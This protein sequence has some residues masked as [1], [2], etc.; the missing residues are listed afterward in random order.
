MNKARFVVTV[1][2]LMAAVLIVHGRSD[3]DR[4]PFRAPLSQLPEQVDSRISMDIPIDAGILKLLGDGYFLNRVY[5][6]SAQART[7]ADFDTVGLFIAYFPTQRSGQ[8]IHSPQN[9]LPG[10]GW[11]FVSSRRIAIANMNGD[12]GEYVITNGSMKQLVLYWYHAHGKSIANDYA[13]KA[14]MMLDAIRYG[15]TDGALI[16]IITPIESKEEYQ[17]AHERATRFASALAPVLPRFLP[18]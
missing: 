10:A 2:S 6:S 14:Y 1:I 3:A 4:V 13:A 5:Q 7:G 11:S 15:R 16:R 9:C 17:H 12:V 18:D 8:A